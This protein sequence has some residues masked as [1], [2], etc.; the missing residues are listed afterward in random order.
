[1]SRTVEITTSHCDY[2]HWERK[3]AVVVRGR[4]A[5]CFVGRPVDCVL[6]CRDLG[7]DQMKENLMK[8]W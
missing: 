3:A 2:F 5:C 1:M 7:L 8:L 6:C 4:A